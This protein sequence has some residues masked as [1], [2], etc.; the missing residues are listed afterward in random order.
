MLR[1]VSA[2]PTLRRF[3][4]RSRVASRKV[5]TALRQSRS[6]MPAVMRSLHVTGLRPRVASRKVMTSFRESRRA[7][8]AAKRNLLVM[9]LPGEAQSIWPRG[10]AAEE[11]FSL[12]VVIAAW[13]GF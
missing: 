6:A 4:A 5:V 7:M 9:L 10:A 11:L 3:R 13:R 2:P 1:G 12:A 8:T